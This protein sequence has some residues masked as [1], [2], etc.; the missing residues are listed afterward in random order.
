[1]NRN[2]VTAR[3]SREGV[4]SAGGRALDIE[5]TTYSEQQLIAVAAAITAAP[6]L[7]EV[8]KK[9]LALVDVARAEG[10]ARGFV[11]GQ[12]ELRKQLPAVVRETKFQ[13]DSTGR[14]VG[15]TEREFKPGG[16]S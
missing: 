6:K 16:K 3:S 9:A 1:M 14:I 2:V 12:E 8:A 5:P 15:K 13:T 10:Y 11:A 4:N 7:L